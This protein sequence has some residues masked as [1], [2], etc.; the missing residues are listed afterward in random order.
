MKYCPIVVIDTCKYS[1]HMHQ[2][3]MKA[4]HSIHTH[5][6]QLALQQHFNTINKRTHTKQFLF[7]MMVFQHEH[8]QS[9]RMLYIFWINVTYHLSKHLSLQYLFRQHI[10]NHLIL[11]NWHFLL[12][13]DIT[14]V[15]S[16]T[17]TLIPTNCWPTSIHWSLVW[18]WAIGI[19][20]PTVNNY[21]FSCI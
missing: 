17:P 20:H 19:N 5:C 13:I 6:F 10:K 21:S 12:T 7:W 3:N 15:S 18:G 1:L 16:R 2:K 14:I 8:F 4:N 11:L 9:A